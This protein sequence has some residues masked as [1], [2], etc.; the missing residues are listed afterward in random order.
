LY[1]CRQTKVLSCPLVVVR[2][3]V[4][5]REVVFVREVVLVQEVVLVYVI[6]PSNMVSRQLFGTW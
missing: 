4:L 6:V 2:E 1:L 5:I 3:V